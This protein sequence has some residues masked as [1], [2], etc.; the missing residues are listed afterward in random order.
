MAVVPANAGTHTPFASGQYG[1]SRGCRCKASRTRRMGS[2]LR[3]N[4][5]LQAGALSTSGASRSHASIFDQLCSTP[6]IGQ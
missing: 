6:Q 1:P 4:D 2:R 5:G 3:G